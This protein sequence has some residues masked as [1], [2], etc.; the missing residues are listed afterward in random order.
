MRQIA[1]GWLMYTQ[2]HNGN[3][4]RGGPSRSRRRHERLQRRQRR[5]LPPALVCPPGGRRDAPFQQPIV[6]ARR[7]GQLYDRTTPVPLSAEPEWRNNRTTRTATLPVPRQHALEGHR[8]DRRRLEPH[9]I[10]FPVKAARI[11]AAQTVMAADSMGT[12]AGKPKHL[13]TGYNNEGKTT[14]SRW[15]TTLGRSDPP[16]LTATS[17][18]A[19]QMRAARHRSVSRPAPRD[20]QRGVLRRH[21]EAMTLKDMAT[22]STRRLRRRMAPG[23]HTRLFS[24]HRR[25][26]GPPPVE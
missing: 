25:G 4:R 22:S 9:L 6:G 20:G 24:G 7:H 19:D 14:C 26:P 13:L 12:A 23:A 10:N 1:T 3:A 15:A 5:V 11:K 8:R 18:Y 17:D 2:A 16:R 21:V